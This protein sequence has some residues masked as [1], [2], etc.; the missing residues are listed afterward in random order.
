MLLP[1]TLSKEAIMI[2]VITISKTWSMK[3][4]P[5]LLQR[6]ECGIAIT[7]NTVTDVETEKQ[8]KVVEVLKEML[9]PGDHETCHLEILRRE[10]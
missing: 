8:G 5:T 1:I 9:S 4:T 6:I 7:R 10:V 2:L 3:Q